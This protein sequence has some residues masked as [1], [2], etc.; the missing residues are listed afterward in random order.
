[1]ETNFFGLCVCVLQV[2]LAYEKYSVLC[3]CSGKVLNGYYLLCDHLI[4]Y[5]HVL[6]NYYK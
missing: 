1:M 6:L 4:C 2:N 3:M 5:K